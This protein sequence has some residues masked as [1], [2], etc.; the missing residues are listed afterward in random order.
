[1]SSIDLIGY[2]AGALV[3]GSLLPQVIQ[4]W[5]TRSTKDLSLWRHIIYVAG[6]ILWQ[7]Y[8][9]AIDNGPLIVMNAIGLI[10]ASSILYLK[11]KHG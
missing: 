5:K 6:L 11:L 4:S 7:I 1:M 2:A 9:F 8:G 3:V 10:L